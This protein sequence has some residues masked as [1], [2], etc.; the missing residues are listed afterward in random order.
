MRVEPDEWNG[1][2]IWHHRLDTATALG[3]W[4]EKRPGRGEDAEPLFVH[5][6]P[7]GQGITGVFDGLGGAGAAAAYE[8][9]GGTIRTGAWVGSRTARTAVES[10]FCA[11]VE[12]RTGA[13]PE[14]LRR[15]LG[16]VLTEMRPVNRSKVTGTAR[17]D[18]PTTMAVTYYR[19]VPGAVY[20]TALW[21]GDSR[22]YVLTPRGGLQ[23]L[24][25]DHTE[26]TDALEQLR[27]DPPMT[28]MLSAGRRFTVGSHELSLEP[29]CVLVTATD[30][31]FGYVRTPADFEHH[32]LRTLRDA[33][34]E[35][36]WGRLLAREVTGY[37]GDDASLSLVA[38]GFGDFWALRDAFTARTDQVES[39]L[40]G[41]LPSDDDPAATRAWEERTWQDYRL[42]YE[43]RMP[44]SFGEGI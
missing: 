38:L 39:V 1:A 12:D 24:M 36:H 23:A 4:T 13:E 6:V 42:G 3:V 40:S 17:K 14:L 10:W 30:G 15:H 18:L 22:A 2:S 32:L 26:E 7:S 5:H 16:E 34:D 29:P 28:N 27:R 43:A 11:R 19:L 41:A 8:S 20:C 33:V 35:A 21:A 25:R 31:F 44:C 9:G 37:T